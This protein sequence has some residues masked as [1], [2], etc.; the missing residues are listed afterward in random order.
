MIGRISLRARLTAA[1]TAAIAIGVVAAAALLVWQV[2]RTQ[3]AALDTAITQRIHDVAAEVTAGRFAAVRSTGTASVS[4]VQVVSAD[5]RVLAN[6]ADIDGEPALFSFAASPATTVL[7]TA[8]GTAAGDRQPFRV[9]TLAV[10]SASDGAVTIYAAAPTSGV[11]QSTAELVGT[12]LVGCPFLIT[13][14]AVITWALVG[15]ALRPVEAMRRQVSALGGADGHHRIP[16]SQAPDELQRLA[17][18]F[19]DLLGRIED[20]G[21]RQRQFLAD[22]AHELR[23]PVAALHTRLD[24][25]ATHPDLALSPHDRQQ[26]AGDTARLSA[27]VDSLLTVARLDAHAKLRL[28]PGDLDDLIFD[29][30]RRITPTTAIGID[31]SHVTAAQVNGDRAALDRVV[32]NLLDNAV[33]HAAHTVTLTLTEATV[34]VTLTVADDGAGIA[35]HDR[36]RVF[37]RFTR[38]DDARTRESGGTGLGLAIVRDI[39]RAHHGTIVIQD[40]H[41]GARLVITLPSP[42]PQP[43]NHFDTG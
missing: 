23:T 26:L 11:D 22:A 31:A 6:S 24:V 13:L 32:A 19:N 25:H 20:S 35:I 1:A 34:G 2:H 17:G 38:L 33:R 39:V 42:E 30:L 4:V 8:S 27:L 18:T 36:E 28:H 10:R 5:G 12:L 9:A 15:R 21:Q 29:Q 3:L 7:H 43:P 16:L 40:N 14:L 37:E 41:P